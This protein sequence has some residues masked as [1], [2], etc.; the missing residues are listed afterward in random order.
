MV[1]VVGGVGNLLGTAIAAMGIGILNYLIGSG[2]LALILTNMKAPQ[3][4][5]DLCFFFATSSM[6]KVLVFALIITFLQL[7]PAGLFPQ[8]GR[9]AEL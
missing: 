3:S 4:V 2:T 8:K 5:L 9:T 1:V 6:A 7:K